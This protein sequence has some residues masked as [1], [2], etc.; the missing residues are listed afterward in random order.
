MRQCTASECCRT[1]AKL[2]ER[3]RT[4]LRWKTRE[5]VFTEDVEDWR[6]LGVSYRWG[7]RPNDV[8]AMAES[9]DGGQCCPA[10]SEDHD[11]LVLFLSLIHQDSL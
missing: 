8:I 1:E 9:Q 11:V 2:E 6:Q 10:Q 5:A 4:S 3:Q 7:L